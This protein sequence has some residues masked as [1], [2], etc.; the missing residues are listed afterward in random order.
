MLVPEHQVY[1]MPGFVDMRKAINGLSMYIEK[2]AMNAFDGSYFVFCGKTRQIIK[3][4]YWEVNG[5]CL[6][7]K[8]L[9]K[10]KFTW[11]KD[12]GEAKKISSREL[13]WLLDGLDPIRVRGHKELTY[14]I[15]I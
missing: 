13:R 7:Q 5:F 8:R 14:S 15:S 10:Q 1:I 9:E 6:W 2:N 12:S 3:I 11:P 4:L